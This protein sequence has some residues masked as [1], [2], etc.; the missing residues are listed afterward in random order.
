MQRPQAAARSAMGPPRARS[1]R[2]PGAPAGRPG[3]HRLAAGVGLAGSRWSWS[4]RV[5]GGRGAPCG[6]VWAGAGHPTL[7]P[8]APPKRSGPLGG[9]RGGVA[10]F[11]RQGL[12]RL[13]LCQV[14]ECWLCVPRDGRSGF[15]CDG[16]LGIHSASGRLS[17]APTPPRLPAPAPPQQGP[18]ARAL[19]GTLCAPEDRPLA[20]VGTVTEAAARPGVGALIPGRPRRV[21]ALPPLLG[22]GH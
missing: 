5:L 22:W 14:P 12:S 4:R 17:P 6:R 2:T 15:L 3:A 20:G 13:S 10:A 16:G 1:P 9:G 11:P 19:L 21:P 7:P 8:P 18:Q